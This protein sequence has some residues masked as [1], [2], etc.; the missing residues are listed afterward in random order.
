MLGR[1]LEKGQGERSA[2]LG[3]R[4]MVTIFA[5]PKPFQGHV[6]RIQRNAI[7]SWKRLGSDV[8]ITLCGDEPGIAEVALEFAVD[9]IPDIETNEFGTPLL[10]SAFRQAQDAARHDILCYANADLIF[11][12]D[13]IEAIVRVSSAKRRFL[14][15]G[16]S[17]DLDVEEELVPLD[18]RCEADL[19]RRVAAEGAARG[20]YWIDFFVF[21]RH[22]IGPLPPFTVGRPGWDN[23][24]IWRAR[25]L[26][27]AVVDISPSMLV[28]HQKHDYAH[29]KG[30]TGYRWRGPEGDANKAFLRPGQGLGLHDCTHQLVPDRLVADRGGL[31]RRVR[32]EVVL[33]SWTI[34][35][36]RALRRVYQPRR[37]HGRSP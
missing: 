11:F 13:L 1:V 37:E 30:A 19:R 31:R 27:F 24:M 36:Y 12:P 23:W 8:Q 17:W 32:T 5:V 16:R 26:R 14:L 21:R 34:P 6:G 25:K 3:W 22:S 2:L 18:E 4:L 35:I 20:L 15:V 28:I 9:H 29:V 7:R 10:H 33:H